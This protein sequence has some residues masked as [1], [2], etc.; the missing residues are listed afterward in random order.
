MSSYTAPSTHLMTATV[1]FVYILGW[2]FSVCPLLEV[3]AGSG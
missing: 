1:T 2:F 3:A